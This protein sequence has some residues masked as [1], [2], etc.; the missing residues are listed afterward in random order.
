M[1]KEKKFHIPMTCGGKE[2]RT[3]RGF[4]VCLPSSLSGPESQN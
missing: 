4:G 2:R 3:G 1:E